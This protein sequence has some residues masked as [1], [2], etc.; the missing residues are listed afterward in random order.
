ME[1]ERLPRVLTE[2]CNGKRKIRN[3]QFEKESIY[4]FIIKSAET[5]TINLII[6]PA[7]NNKI[8]NSF[9]ICRSRYLKLIVLN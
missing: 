6:T 4:I 1:E 2:R 9:V 3:L 8:I 7:H 5:Y